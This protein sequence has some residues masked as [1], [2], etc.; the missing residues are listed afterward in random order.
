MSS[1]FAG[2]TLEASVAFPCP[3]PFGFLARLAFL[4]RGGVRKATLGLSMLIL[5][6]RLLREQ[7]LSAFNWEWNYERLYVFHRFGSRGVGSTL[8]VSRGE[9]ASTEVTKRTKGR[10][11]FSHRHFPSSFHVPQRDL[12]RTL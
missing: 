6:E 5:T 2:L 11:T 1:V 3:P 12:V 7:S 4:V 10:L 9:R 8:P